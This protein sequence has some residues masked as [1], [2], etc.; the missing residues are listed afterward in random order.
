M[1]SDGDHEDTRRLL[2]LAD[3][4]RRLDMQ[5]ALIE[6][7]RMSVA[8]P[9]SVIEAEIRRIAHE[10]VVNTPLVVLT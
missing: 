5:F 1:T 9:A 8:K 10:E 4:I 2:A 7:C 3:E 6:V